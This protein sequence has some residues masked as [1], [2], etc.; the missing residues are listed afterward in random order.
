MK[1]IPGDPPQLQVTGDEAV[2][3]GLVSLIFLNFADGNDVPCG[4]SHWFCKAASQ[5]PARYI[6]GVGERKG[7]ARKF[8][9]KSRK[10]FLA[11]SSCP[12]SDE[13]L[14]A[15][16]VGHWVNAALALTMLTDETIRVVYELGIAI[17]GSP[18][19]DA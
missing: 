19:L 4:P 7:D 11:N 3:L 6:L 8:V 14:S 1:L 13:G 12:V 2:R 9:K 17:G 16:E 15:H 18:S 5:A 10:V